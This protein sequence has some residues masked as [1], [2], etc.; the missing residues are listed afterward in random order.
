MS[1]SDC[2][3]NVLCGSCRLVTPTKMLIR[4]LEQ[5]FQRHTSFNAITIDY[6]H[7]ELPAIYNQHITIPLIEHMKNWSRLRGTES[8]LSPKYFSQYNDFLFHASVAWEGVTCATNGLQE[9]THRNPKFKYCLA[10]VICTYEWVLL[11]PQTMVKTLF[12]FTPDVLACS[13]TGCRYPNANWRGYQSF[14]FRES[15]DKLEL[16]KG[17]YFCAERSGF[18]EAIWAVSFGYVEP[19]RAAWHITSNHHTGSILTST[20]RTS[21]YLW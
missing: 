4:R 18:Q 20:G 5:S 8:C 21:K 11:C 17:F 10:P 12:K 14:A 13:A 2:L 19:C 3:M 7:S 6:L 16:K 15:A 1:S 9:P